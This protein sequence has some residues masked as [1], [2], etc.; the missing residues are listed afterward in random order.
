MVGKLEYFMK[1]TD[2]EVRG[3]VL[4]LCI[5]YQKCGYHHINVIQITSSHLVN[6]H[7]NTHT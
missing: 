7:L 6:M 4:A 1:G 5:L 2:P 3:G